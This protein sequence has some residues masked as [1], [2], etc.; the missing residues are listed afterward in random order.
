MDS[1]QTD[2]VRL[3]EK[4]I[5][6]AQQLEDANIEIERLRSSVSDMHDREAAASS[7]AAISTSPIAENTTT[8]VVADP[9]DPQPL[10]ETSPIRA[11]LS[12]DTSTPNAFSPRFGSPS[13]D[14]VQ[15]L[16]FELESLKEQVR[17]KIVFWRFLNASLNLTL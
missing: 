1:I 15:R 4:N 13:H 17:F 11:T 2:R 3:Q 6:L 12:I 16:R 8:M 5:T 10:A 9:S 7:S 14:V